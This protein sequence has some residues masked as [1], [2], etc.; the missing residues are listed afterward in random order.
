MSA[1][2]RNALTLDMLSPLGFK[3]QIRKLPD[4]NYF[5]QKVSIPQIT[6][7]D[8]EQPNPFVANHH[9]GDHI[10]YGKLDLVFKV[11]EDMNNYRQI[12]SW[13]RGMGF[14]TE[15]QEYQDLV[16]RREFPGAGLKSD[17]SLLITTNLKNPNI[18][19]NFQDC[20][21]VAL[22][23]VDLTTTDTTVN[24]ITCSAR[25]TYT[26]FDIAVLS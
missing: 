20:F 6:L 18:E 10:E 11:D 15:F 25:F 26:Y 4:V 2:D 22:G 24:Y 7:P 17:A 23:A 9:P 21:P 8:V 14:P 12:H 16:N 13:I 3:F 1:L 5:L 19:I